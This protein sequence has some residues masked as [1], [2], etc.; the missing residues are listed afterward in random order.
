MI[1]DIDNYENY[2]LIHI[3]GEFNVS[4]LSE[5][6]KAINSYFKNPKHIIFDFKNLDLIDSSAIGLLLVFS[7][8]FQKMK[9]TIAIAQV[10]EDI[11]Y[12]LN[13]MGFRTKFKIFNTVEQAEE[14][15][16]EF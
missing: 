9:K 15:I 12:I 16:Y 5:F 1:L 11:D 2:D 13:M 10:N 3:N 4:V 14:K 6:E 7:A 8:K